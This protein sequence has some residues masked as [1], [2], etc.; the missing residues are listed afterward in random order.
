MA[1]FQGLHISLVKE[2]TLWRVRNGKKISVWG[3]KG[4][5]IPFTYQVQFPIKV[6][7]NKA[8]VKELIETNTK[9]WKNE[10]L[11]HIF[12]KEEVDT[13]CNIPLSLFSANDKMTW[14]AAKNDLFYVKSAYVLEQSQGKGNLEKSSKGNMFEPKWTAIWNL[15]IPRVVKHFLWKVCHDIL[16]TKLNLFKRKISYTHMLHMWTKRRNPLT[17]LLR[18]FVARVVWGRWMVLCIMGW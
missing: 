13:I 8:K 1:K 6:L 2:G 4:L 5:P 17:Y 11:N 12:T 7:H 3:N 9:F 14:W 18:M 10:L 16:P 15:N